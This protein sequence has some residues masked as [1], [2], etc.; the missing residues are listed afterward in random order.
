MRFYYDSFSGRF[1]LGNRELHCGDC[2]RLRL[3]DKCY[4]LPGAVCGE[5]RDVRIEFTSNQWYL[6]FAPGVSGWACDYEGLHG[7]FA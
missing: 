6:I 5:W 2:F 4:S 1:K 7:E 3:D